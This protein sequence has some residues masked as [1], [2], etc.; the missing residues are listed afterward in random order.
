VLAGAEEQ[1][2]DSAE[3]VTAIRALMAGLVDYAGLFPPASLDMM[4]A[5]RRYGEYLM[6]DDREALGRFVVP[7]ARLEEFATAF[8]E[9]CCEEREPIWQLSVLKSGEEISLDGLTP[10]AVL[11]DSVEMKAAGAA[12]AERMLAEFESGPAAYVEFAPA[13]AAAMLPVLTR[14][15][16]RAKIRTGGVTADAFPSIEAVADF[17]VACAR[18][19][20]PFKATA[21]LHHA[22]R[23]GY[24]LT[25]EAQS[26]RATMHGFVNVFLAAVLAWRGEDKRALMETLALADASAFAFGEESVRW[27]RFDAGVDEIEAA[28]RE[29]AVSYGSCSLTEPVAEVKALGWL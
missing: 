20:V 6:G 16:A 19:K 18:A 4:G 12:Q 11:I 21:G 17:L 22:V 23:G 1:L 2:Q 5:V 9:V 29:F 14:F 26:A 3:V 15:A 27:L 7:A 25:Y 10:G 13:E 8:N 28:R 24:K